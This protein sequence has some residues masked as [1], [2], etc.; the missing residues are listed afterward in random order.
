[1][2]AIGEELQALRRF[3]RVPVHDDHV[4]VQPLPGA[5]E[6]AAVQVVVR[7]GIVEGI[8]H[9]APDKGARARGRDIEDLPAGAHV[10]RGDFARRKMP[11]LTGIAPVHHAPFVVPHHVTTGAPQLAHIVRL[12]LEQVDE[13]GLADAGAHLPPIDDVRM[14][15]RHAQAG[16]VRD[17]LHP[18]ARRLV[19]RLVLTGVRRV[20]HLRIGHRIEVHTLLQ[21]AAVLGLHHQRRAWAPQDIDEPAFLNT[22]ILPPKGALVA[23]PHAEVNLHLLVIEGVERDVLLRPVL[24]RLHVQVGVVEL[25]AVSRYRLDVSLACEVL[26]LD[27]H[28]HVVLPEGLHRDLLAEARI[29]IR[30]L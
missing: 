18:D 3:A 7:P 17:V 4:L 29:A 5:G 16:A 10:L 19:P 25:G 22:G 13:R 30:G 14:V 11:P 24:R 21:D 26:R 27:P 23:A 20:A 6:I 28:G 8:K 12:A 9:V 15:K 1:M 2:P